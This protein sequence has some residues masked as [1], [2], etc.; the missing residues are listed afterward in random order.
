MK[1]PSHIFSL[2]HWMAY[3][4]SGTKLKNLEVIEGIGRT[5]ENKL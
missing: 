4:T 3:P 5:L 1:E 2:I